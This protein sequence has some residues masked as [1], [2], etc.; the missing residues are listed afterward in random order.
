MNIGQDKR[1]TELSGV[2]TVDGEIIYV[3]K[4][5]EKNAIRYS[6]FGKHKPI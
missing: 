3:Q 4:G 6:V 5:E 2:P 1:P